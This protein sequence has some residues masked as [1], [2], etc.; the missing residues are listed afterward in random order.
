MPWPTLP[1]NACRWAPLLALCALMLNASPSLA[2]ETGMSSGERDMNVGFIYNFMRFTEWPEDV[3]GTLTLCIAGADPYGASL[4]VLQGKTLG[5][6][7]LTV[8][9]RGEE[10]L[11]GCQAVFFSAAA[12]KA[13]AKA[14]AELR[15][16]PVL[17][18]ADSPGATLQGVHLNMTV[19]GGKIT[20]EANAKVA[21]A[22]HLKLNRQMLHLATE[23]IE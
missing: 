14:L 9:R 23:V 19:A 17:T 5:S 8:Q 16:K 15:G 10:S 20:F 12:D 21:L 18:M 13:V 7:R 6:R 4:D 1:A 2:Q 3:G 22:A 11:K